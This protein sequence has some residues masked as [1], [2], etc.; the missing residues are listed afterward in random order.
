MTDDLDDLFKPAK[1]TKKPKADNLDD[2]FGTPKKSA[3]TYQKMEKPKTPHP[4]GIWTLRENAEKEGT[5]EV[6]CLNPACAVELKQGKRRP[7][8]ICRKPACF[9]AYRAAYRLDYDKTR[10][11]WGNIQHHNSRV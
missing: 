1:K 3:S 9:K 7:R 4:D 10:G 2:L 5:L 6:N 8:V 11:E